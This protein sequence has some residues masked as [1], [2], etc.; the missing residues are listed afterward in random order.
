MCSQSIQHSDKIL[1]NHLNHFDHAA[2]KYDFKKI[3]D[4]IINNLPY[5]QSRNIVRKP[6]AVLKI[7]K[8][9]RINLR[10]DL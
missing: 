2:E 4:E 10:P 9:L 3:K 6:V 5:R 8:H 7:E 1:Y